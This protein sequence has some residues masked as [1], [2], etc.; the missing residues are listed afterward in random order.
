VAIEPISVYLSSTL[1]DLAEERRLV[2]EVLRS[3]CSITESYEPSDAHLVKKCLDDISKCEVYVGVIGLRYGFIPAGQEK[4]ITQL[5]YEHAK[6]RKLTRFLFIKHEDAVL[7][8]MTDAH[9]GGEHPMDRIQAFRKQLSSG[10]VTDTTPTFFKTID[11]L[12]SALQAMLAE[13]RIRRTGERTLFD[14]PENHPWAIRY[15]VAFGCVPG[16]DHT[17]ASGLSALAAADQRVSVFDLSP[18]TDAYLSTLDR[19]ARTSRSVVLAITA[20]AVSR[21]KPWVDSIAHAVTTVRQRTGG[22][23]GLLVD[24]KLEDLPAPPPPSRTTGWRRPA[25]RRSR[26]CSRGVPC[27]SPKL[28]PRP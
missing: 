9:A 6:R 21:L 20:A 5:E 17:L 26:S 28:V 24:V 25:V 15:D 4:S 3:G 12:R 22:I 18:D 14:E 8:P 13:L 10:D 11:D 19:H 16:T 27:A 1:K 2:A 23:F 7:F